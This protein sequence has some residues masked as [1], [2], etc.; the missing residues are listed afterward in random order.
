MRREEL[1]RV[2]LDLLLR[3]LLELRRRGE[4]PD[5][6]P[7]RMA[8]LDEPDDRPRWL[9][10]HCWT[11]D[12]ARRSASSTWCSACVR[13][14]SAAAGSVSTSCWA[15]LEMPRGLGQ[16]GARV[17]PHRAAAGVDVVADGLDPRRDPTER[18]AQGDARLLGLGCGRSQGSQ[19]LVE[20]C[21]GGLQSADGLER[22]VAG[23]ACVGHGLACR[24]GRCRDGRVGSGESSRIV[25]VLPD[26]GDPLGDLLGCGG[27]VGVGA[28]ERVEQR[29]GLAEA[30]LG[31]LGVHHRRGAIVGGDGGGA[32][33][34][35]LH[36]LGRQ[37]FGLVD[38]ALDGGQGR[39]RV[40]GPQPLQHGS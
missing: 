26:R 29:G 32:E 39:A 6:M 35:L 10:S 23:L 14:F 1:R 28:V 38:V 22:V 40:I 33:L 5:P 19:Q 20:I 18:L 2:L 24:A 31:G 16:S 3:L 11:S 12:W 17:G 21:L 27:D 8:P 25:E 37:P 36:R 13:A 7:P 9:A 34:G 4:D 30:L 15:L